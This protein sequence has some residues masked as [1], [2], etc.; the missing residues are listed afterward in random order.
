MANDE[1]NP[2][3]DYDLISSESP[4]LGGSV[5]EK[6]ERNAR[7]SVERQREIAKAQSELRALMDEDVDDGDDVIHGTLPLFPEMS[8]G[9]PH[10]W[11]R[12]SLFCSVMHG[13][14]P[15]H[16]QVKLA[17]RSDFRIVYT[18]EQLDMADNDVFLHVIKMSENQST[19]D[20]I[21]F[22]RSKFLK[23]IN[24]TPGTSGYNWLESSLKRLAE[25]TIFIEDTQGKGEMF[26]LIKEMR[27]DRM[28][29]EY[30]IRI[31]PRIITFFEISKIAFIN[32]ESRR[33]YKYQLSKWLQNYVSSHKVNEWHIISIE[34][35]MQ[36]AGIQGRERD[37]INKETRGL[38]KA[39]NELVEGGD[40]SSD[41]EIYSRT[42]AGEKIAMVKWFRLSRKADA[43]DEETRPDKK[44]LLIEGTVEKLQPDFI[45]GALKEVFG[46]N[47]GE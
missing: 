32:L 26:R 34:N 41:W 13:V 35:I 2:E 14:R 11:T 15:F 43:D 45:A 29:E 8:S 4:P 6:L 46:T 38:R 17:T 36:W 37:F 24:R 31:D 20:R 12:T 23:Q 22:V 28:S 7:L 9:M 44:P 42:K 39:L 30:W 40:I 1:P 16:K 5:L 19:R 18:G 33:R 27:W 21:H 3:A 25:A 47:G 10:K